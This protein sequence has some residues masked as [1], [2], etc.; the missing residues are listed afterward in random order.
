MAAACPCHRLPG[1]RRAGGERGGHRRAAGPPVRPR[2][3][4]GRDRRRLGARLADRLHRGDQAPVAERLRHGEPVDVPGHL[5]AVLA[6][7]RPAGEV[8]ERPDEPRRVDADQPRRGRHEDR[9][10][11]PAAQRRHGLGVPVLGRRAGARGRHRRHRL[12]D[13]RALRGEGGDPRRAPVPARL[14]H[15]GVGL[16]RAGGEPAVH[17]CPG[18]GA[19]RRPGGEGPEPARHADRRLDRVPHLLRRRDQRAREL[20]APLAH[21]GLRA[22]RRR[23]RGRVRTPRSRARPARGRPVPGVRG[24]VRAVRGA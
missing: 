2:R 11:I 23:P 19:H 4:R 7:G 12:Q 22:G 20:P 16:Q 6:P 15:G 21:A 13:R 24:G 9:L 18:L 14:L 5:P 17:R 8:P 3:G 1:W 10:A